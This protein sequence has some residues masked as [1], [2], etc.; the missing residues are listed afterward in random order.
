MDW[1]AIV[2]AVLG[3]GVL[4]SLVLSGHAWLKAHA[5]QTATPWDDRALVALDTVSNM[6][7]HNS[8]LATMIA[9]SPNKLD[10]AALALLQKL[11]DSNE[12]MAAEVK[13]A[14]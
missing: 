5:A 11:V 7:A 10:D 9:N 3:S 1:Q 12:K 6:A 4:V 8:T 13:P 2:L 14:A